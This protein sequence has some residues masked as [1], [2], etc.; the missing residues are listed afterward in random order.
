[1][2]RMLTITLIVLL[3]LGN[4]IYWGSRKEGFHIDEMFS[5]EQVGNTKYPRLHHNRPDEPYLNNWHD[6]SYYEDYLTINTDSVFDIVGFYQSARK[7][8]AHPPLYLTTLGMAI[9]AISP[10][11]FTKWSGIA[12]N[13]FLYIISFG[14]ISKVTCYM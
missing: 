5:Y 2:K 11:H 7:N 9:S 6:R 8:G 14:K 4:L 10:N 1:M 3:L 12:L 13:I